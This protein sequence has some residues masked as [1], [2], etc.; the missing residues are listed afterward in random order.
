MRLFLVICIL[1]SQVNAFA[2]DKIEYVFDQN[3][4]TEIRKFLK[5]TYDKDTLSKF[6]FILSQESAR[7]GYAHTKLYIG[8]Y[9]D[10]PIYFVNAIIQASSRIYKYAGIQIPICFDYDFRFISYGQNKR[11]VVRKTLT[12]EVFSIE[13]S[14]DDEIIKTGY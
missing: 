3:T 7:D 12:G 6:Y 4:D 2:Q 9:K 13:F 8:V 10:S 11:G 1:A 14:K 5:T